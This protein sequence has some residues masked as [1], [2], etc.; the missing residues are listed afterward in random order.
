MVRPFGSFRA[1]ALNA[2]QK[3]A[4]PTAPRATLLQSAVF[5]Q[6]FGGSVGGPIQ[7]DKR[8][9]SSL[10]AS[11]AHVNRRGTDIAHQLTW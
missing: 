5:T 9:H 11:G 1:Q 4:D 7:K 6:W 2:D 10:G 3:L 8:L